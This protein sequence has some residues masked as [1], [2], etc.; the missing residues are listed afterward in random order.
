MVDVSEGEDAVFE[1]AMEAGAAD[2]QPATDDDGTVTG[3]KVRG[4]GLF[5]SGREGRR[6]HCCW[7]GLWAGSEGS[8]GTSSATGGS[9]GGAGRAGG[10]NARAGAEWPAGT[11]LLPCSSTCLPLPTGAHRCRGLRLRVFC[12]G[13]CGPQDRARVVGP[14][15]HPAR[16]AGGLQRRHT[17]PLPPAGSTLVLVACPTQRTQQHC[18]QEML[19]AAASRCYPRGQRLTRAAATSTAH[20]RCL[21]AVN[22]MPARPPACL[23]ARLFACLPA[24]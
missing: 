13:G 2:F 14:G 8:S 7:A 24:N 18:E 4:G 5:G 17:S 12:A 16:A 15:V 22:C 1:A 20:I 21:P 6:R 23:P 11:N 9:G 19:A 10:R 3:F